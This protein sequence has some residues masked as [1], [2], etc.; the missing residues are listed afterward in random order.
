[1]K[2]SFDMDTTDVMNDL[3]SLERQL[4]I[5]S[6]TVKRLNDNGINIKLKVKLNSETFIKRMSKKFNVRKSN[7]E[8]N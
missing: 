6:N 2:L 7:L 1:M 8:S 5:L 3:D 4:I